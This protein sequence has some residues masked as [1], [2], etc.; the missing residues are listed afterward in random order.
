MAYPMDNSTDP[1]IRNITETEIE[2]V[3]GSISKMNRSTALDVLYAIQG[4]P[5][6]MRTDASGLVLQKLVRL[7]GLKIA[8]REVDDLGLE[9]F[10]DL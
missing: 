2:N 10:I 4:Q 9:D 5:H 8:D 6:W 1:P 3:F 7:A